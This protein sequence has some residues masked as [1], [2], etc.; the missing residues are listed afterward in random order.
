[1]IRSS[2]SG[3]MESFLFVKV[4]ISVIF[5]R[6]MPNLMK[7]KSFEAGWHFVSYKFRKL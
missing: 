7:T 4:I 1:M 2:K 5:R 3:D 6:P